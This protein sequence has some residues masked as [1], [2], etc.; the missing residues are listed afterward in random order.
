MFIIVVII[1]SSYTVLANESNNCDCDVLQINDPYGS[2]GNQ[3][4]TRQNG[5]YNEK[6]YYVSGQWNMISWNNHFWSYD[7]YN[8]KF[9]MIESSKIHSPN[10]FS[11]EHMC[12]NV[13]KKVFWNGS[14]VKSRCLRDNSNCSATNDFSM[15]FK[16]KQVKLHSKDSCK[17]PFIYKNVTYFSCIKRGK[18]LDKFGC[19]TTVDFTNKVTSWGYCND[20]CPVQD[21]G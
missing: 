7:T 20:L 2:I 19:A 5:T 1:Y 17:F 4:F 13:T 12:Q 3:N 10:I 6:P 21:T 9:K 8:S 16:D 15:K 18:Y 14:I 11:F